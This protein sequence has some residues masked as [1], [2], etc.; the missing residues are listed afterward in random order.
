[1]SYLSFRAFDPAMSAASAER[2]QSAS[3]TCDTSMVWVERL[4]FGEN[5]SLEHP[6]N[7]RR[8]LYE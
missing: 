2:S 8:T 7:C 5:G 6:E 4:A 1:M 3:S